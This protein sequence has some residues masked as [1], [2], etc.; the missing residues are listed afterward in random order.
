MRF[1]TGLEW[2][3]EKDPVSR[4]K[5]NEKAIVKSGAHCGGVKTESGYRATLPLW[6][7]LAA[8]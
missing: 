5:K 6:S 2:V 3:A 7:A 1:Q 4:Q 8:E